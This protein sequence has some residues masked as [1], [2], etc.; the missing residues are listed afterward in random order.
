MSLRIRFS[1]TTNV[2]RVRT[3]N[4][5]SFR[6]AEEEGLAV[7]ADG[8][9][10]HPGGD[11]ASKVAAEAALAFLREA[12]RDAGEDP[13]ALEEIMA[14]SVLVAHE[15]VRAAAGEHPRLERM[16]TTLTALRADLPTRTWALGH[17]GDS[18]AYLLR[19]GHLS[20]VSHDDTWVQA[21]VDAGLLSADGARAHPASH[22]LQQC[23]GLETPPTPHRSSGGLRAGDRFLLCSD[24]LT[25]MLTD[26]EIR[27]RLEE[28]VGEAAAR[29]LVEG[30][31]ERGGRDNVTVVLG[32]VEEEDGP[33]D[34]AA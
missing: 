29:A 21:R 17:A 12:P 34:G 7:V 25:D 4:E 30:A 11:V 1:G 28:P 27:E 14:R 2:G 18:R 23:V 26:A 22:V 6:V 24:G 19:G 20:Q 15:A 32:D 8:M 13:A 3:R 33:G 10:G 9:G 31:L 5:D 16:G